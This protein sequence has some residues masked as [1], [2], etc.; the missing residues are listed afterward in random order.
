[1]WGEGV[2]GRGLNTPSTYSKYIPGLC[3]RP[4]VKYYV[5]CVVDSKYHTVELSVLLS[6]TEKLLLAI[7]YR[8]E[9][10]FDAFIEQYQSTGKRLVP[11]SSFSYL[12]IVGLTGKTNYFS[13]WEMNKVYIYLKGTVQRI[14]TGVNTMLK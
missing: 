8:C 6:L 14:L 3:S 11:K 4:G 1:V 12:H 13:F 2:V 9:Q 7:N 10:F 5:I